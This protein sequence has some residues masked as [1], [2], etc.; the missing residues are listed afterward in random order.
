MVFC[1]S[2]CRALMQG[3]GAFQVENGD[4]TEMPWDM[5]LG[6]LEQ[7]RKLGGGEG[8]EGCRQ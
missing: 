7:Q 3:G 5:G 4:M 6:L 2:S 8:G 1:C